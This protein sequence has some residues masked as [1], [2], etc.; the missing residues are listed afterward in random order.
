MPLSLLLQDVANALRRGLEQGD[1]RLADAWARVVFLETQLVA[2]AR[3]AFLI[4]WFG[5][6]LPLHDLKVRVAIRN[7]DALLERYR[8][9]VQEMN[10]GERRRNFLEPAAGLA[11][12]LFGSLSSPITS[13]FL[14]ERLHRLKQ[15]WFTGVGAALNVLTLGTLGSFIALFAAGGAAFLPLSIPLLATDDTVKSTHRL[16]GA[17]AEMFGPFRRFWQALTGP[18]DKL[19]N[20]VLRAI[21]NLGDEAANLVPFLMGGFAILI[22]RVGA[23]LKPLSEQVPALFSLVQAVQPAI[24]FIVDDFMERLNGLYTGKRSPFQVIM[25]ILD[26]LKRLTPTLSKGF[27]NAFEVVT[28]YLGRSAHELSQAWKIWK[29]TAIPQIKSVVMDS[30]TVLTMTAFI[31]A[32]KGVINIFSTP[33]SPPGKFGKIL[34]ILQLPDEARLTARFGGEPPPLEDIL[35]IAK[36]EGGP[37]AMYVDP[38]PFT[39]KKDAL[40][41]L[42]IARHP[43][44]V[45]AGEELTLKEE[46]T[47][48]RS[49]DRLRAEQNLR[50]LLFE[51]VARVMPPVAYGYV[52]QLEK[53]FL[54]IDEALK[55][56]DI[57]KL[58]G[59]EIARRRKEGLPVR[60]LE[61]EY[62]L[63]PLVSRLRVRVGGQSSDEPAVREWARQLVEACNKQTYS[64]PLPT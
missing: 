63:L 53:V 51:V 45:F 26:A 44:S 58:R 5:P 36:G 38:T 10:A 17:V 61:E 43:P 52:S 31:D 30:P 18:R 55:R 56:E 40:Q 41:G 13:I 54:K 42:E 39:L 35:R 25:V 6:G 11:A 29:A 12:T 24:L 2:R 34:A 33:G 28:A 60:D 21:L 27:G 14:Y 46:L 3:F 8:V 15:R 16:L 37:L 57:D 4:H 9:V 20:P 59:E 62:R 49:L 1:F 7:L 23:V 32:I 47:Q 48:A 19:R 50:D 64:A 22:I